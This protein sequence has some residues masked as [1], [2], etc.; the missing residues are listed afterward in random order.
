MGNRDLP[1]IYAHVLGPATL[2]LGHI[3]QAN[4]SCPCYNY[5]LYNCE[6]Y[7]MPAM[8]KQKALKL[9]PRS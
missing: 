7:Q 2:G 3:Y 9:E 8:I 4:P 5:Y 1:D 6:A